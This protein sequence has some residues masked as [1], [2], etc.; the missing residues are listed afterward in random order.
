MKVRNNLHGLCSCHESS[1]IFS[2]P[3]ILHD[4]YIAYDCGET[5]STQGIPPH[6][7]RASYYGGLGPT[8]VGVSWSLFAVATILLGLRVVTYT[9]IVKN[10]GGYS[11]TMA[12]VAWVQTALFPI[13]LGTCLQDIV[14]W[15]THH[16]FIH[17]RGVQRARRS[18][19]ACRHEPIPAKCPL[20]CT[21]C[22]GRP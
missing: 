11:L 1:S 14:S 2:K 7:A 13:H 20:V 10:R 9:A 8:L 12:C 17:I 22:R 15:S 18:L 21:C 5:M 4:L 3:S 16:C 6:V 19:D